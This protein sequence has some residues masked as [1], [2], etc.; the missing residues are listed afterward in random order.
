LSN[1]TKLSNEPDLLIAR[2]TIGDIFRSNNKI[3]EYQMLV[4]P[5]IITRVRFVV[6]KFN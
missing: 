6:R 3:D 2:E 1:Y 4:L 5:I